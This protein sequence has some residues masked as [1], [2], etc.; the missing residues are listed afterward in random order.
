MPKAR[1]I[2]EKRK[3]TEENRYKGDITT[4]DNKLMP[5]KVLEYTE[6]LYDIQLAL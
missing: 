5:Q 1:S 2:A 6:G 4:V 3:F